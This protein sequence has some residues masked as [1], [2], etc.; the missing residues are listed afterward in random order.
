METANDAAELHQIEEEL[1]VEILPGTEIMTDTGTHHFLKGSSQV[2]VPQ[3]SADKSDPLNW[4][5]LW[6]GLSIATAT[7][8]SFS[9]GLGPLALAPIFPDLIASFDSDLAGAA[10]FTGITILV[11]GFSNFIWVPMSTAFGRRPVYLLSQLIS[12]GSCIWRARAQTYGSFMGA[13]VLHG[14]GAGP[15]EAIQPAVIAD[16]F[17]LHDRGFWNTVYWTTYMGSLTV[18]P[19][20]SGSMALHTGWRSF[21]WFNTALIGASFLM[22]LFL[23]PE[24]MWDRTKATEISG[25]SKS[26]QEQSLE[27]IEDSQKEDLTSPDVIAPDPFPKTTEEH[28]IWLGKGRPSK[29]Q[30]SFSQPCPDLFHTLFIAFWTPWKLFVFPI[31]EFAAFVVSWSASMFL[32]VNLTQSQ[33]FAAPPYN[34]NTE[35][36]GLFNL[37]ILIGAFI[38]LATAGPLSDYVSARATKKKGGIRE[39]E[40]RLPAMIPYVLLM[41]L[42][43]F[44]VAYGY[45]QKWPWQAIVV[46]GYGSTGIQMAALPAIANT[47]AVDSY[48]PVAGSLM[49]A[50]TVNKNL[51]GYGLSKF[52]TPWVTDSGFVDPILTNMALITLWCTFGGLFYWKGKTI[53]RW[54]RNSSVHRL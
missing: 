31:V 12:L 32:V 40:M 38:G 9:Q 10:Q 16:V 44:V 36:I 52:I 22:V 39:P 49:V 11:L 19:I 29:Q 28:D 15:A 14:I 6:K 54:S 47:Y 25:T 45:E 23:F 30:W 21:W 26:S 33:N 27:K 4:S 41:I 53:R 46:V 20:I 13:C 5:P 42:G 2:L 50:I 7:T 51:W 48:K 3:P 8:V 37:A 35:E 43:N 17:F 1:H 18:G 24:T 34:Y